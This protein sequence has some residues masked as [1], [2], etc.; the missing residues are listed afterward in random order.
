MD[1][2][3]VRT[4]P[5]FAFGTESGKVKDDD[6]TAPLA[7]AWGPN[8][9]VQATVRS[10]HQK[11]EVYEEVEL[12]LRSSLLTHKA[13]G[14]EI[15]FRCSKTEKAYSETVGWKWT[16]G[17]LHLPERRRRFTLRR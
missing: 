3:N 1:W 16:V 12:R 4:T 6:S 13:T 9:T 5:G 11:R 8:Q 10:V 15:D 17:R 2:A 7:G 14:Y